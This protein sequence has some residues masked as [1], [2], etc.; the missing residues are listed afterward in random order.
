MV[1]ANRAARERSGFGALGE[2]GP[3]PQYVVNNWNKLFRDAEGFAHA[4]DKPLPE[5]ADGEWV[6]KFFEF[7]MIL[8]TLSKRSY[9]NLDD[10]DDVLKRANTR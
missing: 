2:H 7:E 9:E 4:R 1:R 10:L 6:K 3:S 5:E 8:M